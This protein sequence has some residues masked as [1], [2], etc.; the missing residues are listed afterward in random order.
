MCLSPGGQN[1]EH[2]CSKHVEAWN[3]LIVKAT[4]CASIWLITETD[5]L[6]CTVSKTSK[7]KKT[8]ET[9]HK[10]PEHCLLTTKT[11]IPASFSSICKYR[12]STFIKSSNIYPHSQTY[13]QEDATFH[14]LFISLRRSTCFRRFFRPSSGAQNCT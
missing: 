13:N 6:R 14:N 2:M 7:K 3:I 1:D 9:Y 10:N 11:A 5:I 8:G 12:L 4:F